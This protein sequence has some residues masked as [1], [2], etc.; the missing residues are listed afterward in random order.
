MNRID[1]Y[2][3]M[4]SFALPHIRNVQTHGPIRKARDKS[5]YHEAELLHNIVN[6]LKGTE[7]C[8]QDIYFLN[9]QARYY[10]ENTSDKICTNY[11]FHKK[12]IKMLFELVPEAMRSQLVWQ[13][14]A[15]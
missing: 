5:C 12:R 8:D 2:I 15:D 4:L 13:G 7:I 1:I 9:N 3:D 14:P 11:H 6:S 10:L